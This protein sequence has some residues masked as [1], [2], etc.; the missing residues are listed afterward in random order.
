[1]PRVRPAALVAI[2][3]RAGRV[4]PL[5]AIAARVAFVAFVAFATFAAPRAAS[6]QTL[7]LPGAGAPSTVGRAGSG[8]VAAD[9][10]ASLWLNPAGLAR[11]SAWRVQLGLTWVT[12]SGS[13]RSAESF[14]PSPAE[15]R[16]L[17]GPS[18]VPALAVQG[19][20]GERVVVGVSWLQPTD[21]SFAWPTP[22]PALVV[23]SEAQDQ[24]DRP[25]YPARYAAGALS[26]RS[27]GAA[28]ATAVRALPWLAL[29]ASAW[30]LHVEASQARS[31]WGGQG[32][33]TS[34]PNLATAFDLQLETSARG[35]VPGGAVG[36]LIAPLDA[37]L[38]LAVAIS[39]TAGAELTGTPTLSDSRG[40]PPGGERY[41]TA[42]VAP[43]ARAT[44][45]L[46]GP[47]VA[48]AG[49]RFFGERLSLET[50][51][52]VARGGAATP[53]W[54]IDGV[55]LAFD[56]AG[57]GPLTAVPLGATLRDGW[58]LGAA[59]DADAVPGFLTLTAG[60]S[61][62][63]GVVTR[64][65]QSPALPVL[66]A[67][68]VALGATVRQGDYSVVLGVSYAPGSAVRIDPGSSAVI[69]PLAQGDAP[70]ARGGLDAS[71]T[72]V[73]VA[74]ETEL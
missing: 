14:N 48:R 34:V 70:A 29:G 22:D 65:S 36:V 25:R 67:H 35:F 9:D 72:L 39:W 19:G 56:G 33:I 40:R 30:L 53:T 66:D 38:E 49:V 4:H 6:A 68:T 2:A 45:S 73:G 23:E 12:R 21:L 41:V 54:R 69:A 16:Q 58:S 50:S 42:T 71:T 10:G 61:Y 24:A 57:S 59:L 64:G 27:R 1:M 62:A 13:F 7:D 15:A 46:P 55:T 51:A 8:V 31:I 17:A 74:I 37:P 60:W 63:R 28:A 3:A 52:A 44:I 43:G 11:R 20:L 47:V 5:V 26:L 32:P 18:V